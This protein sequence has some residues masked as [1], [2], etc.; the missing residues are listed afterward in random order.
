MY[1]TKEEE[2]NRC[3]VIITRFYLDV[4]I[5]FIFPLLNGPILS[6]FKIDLRSK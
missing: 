1:Q 3:I 2:G 5:R 4:K 6:K